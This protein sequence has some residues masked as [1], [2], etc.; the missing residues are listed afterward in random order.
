MDFNV[1]T[2]FRDRQMT[3]SMLSNTGDIRVV[4]S[5][6]I[7]D[8]GTEIVPIDG[9]GSY[10]SKEDAQKLSVFFVPY[11]RFSISDTKYDI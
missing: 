1:F 2:V 7:N 4:K 6:N 9:Y 11:K 3:N 8:L 10:I 5:R